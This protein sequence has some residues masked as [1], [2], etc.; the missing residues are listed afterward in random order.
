MSDTTTI[1]ALISAIDALSADDFATL[2]AQTRKSILPILPNGFPRP[3]NSVHAAASGRGQLS[4][5][6][7]SYFDC[8]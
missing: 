4:E 3:N 2:A 7:R 1:K 8:M 5:A 6:D